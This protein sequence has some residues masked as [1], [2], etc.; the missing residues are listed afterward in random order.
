MVEE[1]K[2]EFRR[3][4]LDFGKDKNIWLYNLKL[5]LIKC[6]LDLNKM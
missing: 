4:N 3:G 1:V 6:N 5:F 2:S